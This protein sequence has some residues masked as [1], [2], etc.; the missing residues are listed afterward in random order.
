M[1]FQARTEGE[2]GAA[3]GSG[4]E[5]ALA[6]DARIGERFELDSVA[7]IW[8]LR[9]ESH[10]AD[11]LRSARGASQRGSTPAARHPNSLICNVSVSGA[12]IIAP[13]ES[14]SVVG[15]LVDVALG[16]GSEFV[17]TIRR[18]LPSEEMGLAFFGVE[19]MSCSDVFQEWLHQ[20]IAS[21]RAR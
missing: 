4:G 3:P 15:Q 1:G 8:S 9:S 7:A 6:F 19:F 10:W 2:P 21:H 13:S 16:P 14:P 12:G 18:V 5:P 17:G 11:R 20:V